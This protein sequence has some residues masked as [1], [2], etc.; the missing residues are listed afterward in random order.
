MQACPGGAESSPFPFL[1]SLSLPVSACLCEADD[2]RYGLSG[3]IRP[4]LCSR[5]WHLS[6]SL[7]FSRMIRA[8]AGDRICFLF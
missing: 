8:G 1:P 4:Y 7:T 5:D 2:S 3:G 6:F